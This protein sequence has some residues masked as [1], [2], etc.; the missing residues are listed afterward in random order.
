MT[1]H[2]GPLKMPSELPEIVKKLNQMGKK[3]RPSEIKTP[4]IFSRFESNIVTVATGGLAF[5]CTIAMLVLCIKHFR[6]KS[7]VSSLGLV[8]LLPA[9]SRSIPFGRKTNKNN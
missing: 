3:T 5:I 9:S 4:L 7:L 2:K 1:I 8:S 6:L